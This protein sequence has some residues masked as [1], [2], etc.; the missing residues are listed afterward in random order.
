MKKYKKKEG[1]AFITALLVAVIGFLVVMVALYIV[2]RGTEISGIEKKYKTSLEASYGAAEIIGKEIIPST[3]GA[4]LSSFRGSLPSDYQNMMTVNVDDTC[5]SRKLTLDSTQWNCSSTSTSDLETTSD[6]QFNFQGNGLA[7][8]IVS[9]KVVETLRGNSNTSGLNL[10]LEGSGVVE[11]GS[12]MLKPIHLP[13]LY[14]I[15]FQGQLEG[16]TEERANLS[17][18]YEY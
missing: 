10:E 13:Y 16:S 9:A 4:S 17:S 11:A 14:R 8:F 18:V 6:I 7:E 3:I 5:W 2:Y 12:G 1:I 15:E